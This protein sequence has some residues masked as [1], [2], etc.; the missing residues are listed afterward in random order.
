MILAATAVPIPA[1]AQY[2]GD[3]PHAG[4]IEIGGAF[5]WT[6][7]YSAGTAVATETRNPSTGSGPLQLFQADGHVAGAP[8]AAAWLGV[9]VSPRMSVEGGLRVSRPKLTASVTNDFEGVNA[10]AIDETLTRYLF[11]G[12]L[13][14]QFASLAG[15]KGAPYVFGG[16]GY[17]RELDSGNSIVHTGNEIH[18]GAGLRYWF[19]ASRRVGLR[20]EGR[21]SSETGT[22]DLDGSTK[23]R[24]VPEFSA[25][26]A[27][28]F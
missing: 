14:Y 3:R 11:D 16:G 4:S 19:G 24:I 22:A 20:A 9:Y 7:G 23:R 21:V 6:A 27:F 17:V 26:F 18:G 13:V 1:F 10:T 5:T 25:G 2:I 8:G 28:L 15:G 12:S